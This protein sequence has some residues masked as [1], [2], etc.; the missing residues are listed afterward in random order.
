MN[1][2][3]LLVNRNN[4]FE[5]IDSKKQNKSIQLK[6]AI[7]SYKYFLI[8]YLIQRNPRQ[9]HIILT[10]DKETAAY[11]Y[12]DLKE[13]NSDTENLFFLPSSYK[14]SIQYHQ[15]DKGNIIL[16]SEVFSV[17]KNKPAIIVSYPEAI[18]E[19]VSSKEEIQ[20]HALEIKKGDVLSIDFLHE[21]FSEYKFEKVD[22]VYEPGQYAIRGGIIDFFSFASEFPVRLDFFGDEVE[23]I[24]KFDIETQLTQEQL[25]AIDILP[26]LQNFTS[27]NEK[28][29]PFFDF[30]DEN[31]CIYSTNLKFFYERV[32]QIY[33]N[34]NLNYE[35]ENGEFIQLNKNHYLLS[36]ALLK[37]KLAKLTKIE[38]GN[39]TFSKPDYVYEFNIKSQPVFNKNFDLLIQDLKE[40]VV[41]HY[42]IFLLSESEHQL[43]RLKHIFDDKGV[44][45]E[46]I[47]QKFTVHEGFIDEKSKVCVYTDHQIFDRYHKFK[48]KSGFDKKETLTIKEI[49]NLQPGDFV[50]HIDHGIG[51]FAGLVKTNNNGKTQESIRLI[52]R[53]GDILDVSIHA[54]HRISKYKGKDLSPPKVHKLG[55]KVWQNLKQTTKNKVKDIAKELIALYAQRKEEQGFAFS[56]DSFMQ[57]ELEASFIYEDTPDQLKAT[58]QVKEDMESLTPMDRLVC[59]DVGFGKTEIAIRAAFKAVADN[60]QVAVLVPTTILALQH[61]KTFG[62]RLAEFPCKIDYLSRLKTSKSQKE[63]LKGIKDGSVDIVIGTHRLLSKDIEFKNLGLLIIDEEQKFGVSSKEKLKQLKVNVDT[64]TLTATPIPRTLQFSLMG[65]R[66]LSVI[67]T[68]PPNRHPILTEVHVFSEQIIKEAIN[69]EFQ[70]NGQ[71]FFIHNRI[72]NIKEI[73]ALVKRINPEVRTVVA[74]GQM[75]GPALEKIMID[76]INY[77]YDV[78][79]A[80]TI[81]ESG[82]DIPNANTIIIN[83]AQNFGL[84]EL[85]QLRGRVGRSN[86]KAF[87]YLI[88]PPLTSL[89]QEA[90]RRLMAIEN[91]S[92]LGSGF[93]IALQ[94]LDI[95][96]AGN[97]LGGEQSGFINDIGIETYHRILNEAILELKENEFRDLFKSAPETNK[98]IIENTFWA[99]DC[100]IDT[101]LEILI[102]ENY[103]SNVSERIHLYRRLDQAENEEELIKIETELKDRFGESPEP[104]K[105]LF[106]IVRL[107]WIAMRL[108]IEK[109]TLKNK[110]LL[111][112]FIT[113]QE[114]LYYKSDVFIRFMQFIQENSNRF[115]IKEDTNKLKLIVKDIKEVK[116]AIELL[117]NV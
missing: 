103:I 80:T 6:G 104:M 24:R 29:I 58:K 17:L 89:T 48:I 72:Q 47:E 7:A 5:E 108:G 92:E 106:E 13:L 44:S 22:F 74:H 41:E 90:R 75:E 37:E 32:K 77:E 35:N 79:I 2:K 51:K 93:N 109:I 28:R 31:T 91:F 87:C 115:S 45:I 19:L 56:V 18:I 113:D 65:A 63:A 12:N 86:K 68:P 98:Q 110:K 96:G 95:R 67:N 78:L 94:D 38:F 76:F 23:S 88:A 111:A 69:Y 14:R 61:Y 57:E 112:S 100:Q 59:G 73:E 34:T 26:D 42:R 46:Y 107:R 117:N 84:S 97:L 55:S 50:V 83:Q 15:E 21:F 81:I 85:H 9:N 8:Q 99:K 71:V 10:E 43:K 4:Q 62:D 54:L 49:N 53:D 25:E 101:D 3:E 82:L 114:S 116:K 66:D 33:N 27:F 40:K 64:L 1:L 36:P 70:R 16:R 30:L 105:Q 20:K 52:Y 102:P 39:T 11:A 60:K